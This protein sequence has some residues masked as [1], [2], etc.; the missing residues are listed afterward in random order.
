MANDYSVRW[1]V[2]EDLP[3]GG[4]AY[5]HKV[6]DKTGELEG[7]FVVKRLINPKRLARFRDEV[8]TLSELDHPG[9]VRLVDF[10]VDAER[11]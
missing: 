9:I 10:D 8:A 7:L 2:I 11:P 1:K 4:Q 5:V 6:E 3:Q